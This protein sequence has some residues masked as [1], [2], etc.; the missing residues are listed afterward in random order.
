MVDTAKTR[1][2]MWRQLNNYVS[3]VQT[4]NDLSPDVQI[5]EVVNQRLRS[6]RSALNLGAWCQEFSRTTRC[7]RQLLAFIYQSFQAYSGIEFSFVRPS[8]RLI[9]DLQ[10]PLVCWFDWVHTFCDDFIQQ[11][12]IDLS[13]SFDEANFTTLADLAIFLDEQVAQFESM[14]SQ[15]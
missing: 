1:E 13:G 9:E 4:Y 11:F 6:K 15:G 14:V 5:R 8:D 3:S 7:D 2:F 12:G 10:L